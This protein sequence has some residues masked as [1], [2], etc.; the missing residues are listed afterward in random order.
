MLITDQ[1]LTTNVPLLFTE[2]CAIESVAICSKDY[3]RRQG[4]THLNNI[5]YFEVFFKIASAMSQN[6]GQNSF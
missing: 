6:V 1:T 2:R 4:F 5:I 3:I